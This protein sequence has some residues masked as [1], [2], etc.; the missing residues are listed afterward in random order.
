[1]KLENWYVRYLGDAYTP[2]EAMQ[3]A[4]VGQVYGHPTRTD[5]KWTCTSPVR[6]IEGRLVTTASGS[7]YE[8]GK[9]EDEYVE[10]CKAKGCHVPTDAEPIKIRTPQEV[11]QLHKE[12]I[13]IVFGKDTEPL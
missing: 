5:G 9:P 13:A 6:K 2:P 12:R 7:V 11:E 3:L 1:M 10:W 4:I 8:L